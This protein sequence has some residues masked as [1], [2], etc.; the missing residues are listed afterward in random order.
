MTRPRGTRFAT[1]AFT[2]WVE[3]RQPQWELAERIPQRYPYV[4]GDNDTAWSDFY[5]YRRRG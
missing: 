2:S 1:T 4:E 5:L 3:R